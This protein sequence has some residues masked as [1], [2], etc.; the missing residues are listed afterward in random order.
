MTASTFACAAPSCRRQQ[1][2]GPWYESRSV[3]PYV[4][5]LSPELRDLLSRI[6]HH[7]PEQRISL[8]G[9]K[10]HSWMSRQ[11][12]LQRAAAWEQPGMWGGTRTV[13]S[14]GAPHTQTL[15]VCVRWRRWRRAP[16]LDSY[17]GESAGGRRLVPQA[18]VAP[19]HTRTL[20][21][22]APARLQAAATAS[23]VRLATCAARAA[24]AGAPD[25]HRAV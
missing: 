14:R 18:A 10:A 2:N 24:A 17:W 12:R 20:V 22:P 16:W 21:L 3:R 19:Y 15:R 25:G 7:D 11:A 13:A 1:L 23:G 8:E 9:I 4:H 5:L 6:L